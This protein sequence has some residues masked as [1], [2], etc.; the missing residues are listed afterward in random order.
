MKKAIFP[1]SFDPL[2]KGHL[3]IIK[4]ASALFDEVIVV[5]LENSEKQTLFTLEERL[6]MLQQDCAQFQNVRVDV[7][8]GLTVAYAKKMGACAM[9]RGVRSIKD[10]EYELS[11]ASANQYLDPAIETILLFSSPAY[12]YVS[13]SV[14]KEMMQYQADISLLVSETVKQALEKKYTKL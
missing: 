14:I 11:I 1:G 8:H 3:D 4:R 7:D 2:T 9:I 5:M 6:D 12:A 13:S 10:Y